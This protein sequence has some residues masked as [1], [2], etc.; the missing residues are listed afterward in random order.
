MEGGLSDPSKEKGMISIEP[1][2]KLEN[3]CTKDNLQV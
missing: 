3:R 1:L 2:E